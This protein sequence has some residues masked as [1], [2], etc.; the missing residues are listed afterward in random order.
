MGTPL[1]LVARLVPVTAGQVTVQVWKNGM[2]R[3]SRTYA[4]GTRI[5]L[6]T[7]GTHAY[8]VAVTSVPR[9]GFARVGR[10]FSTRLFLPTLHPGVQDS[11]TAEFDRPIARVKGPKEVPRNAT[12]PLD[13]RD[14][15]APTGRTI[16]NYRWTI[17][18][19]R[20]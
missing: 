20:P 14:S 18:K 13:G 12:I 2:L 16:T 11:T 17:A 5:A 15:S 4:H 9:P 3:V 19:Q 6:D 8:R 1:A 7:T 10:V